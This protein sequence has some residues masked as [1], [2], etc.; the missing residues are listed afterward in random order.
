LTIRPA[1]PD[2]AAAAIEHTT[3]AI[4]EFP[5]NLVLNPGEFD[6]TLE[7][8]QNLFADV[9]ASDNSA[10]LLALIDDQIVG[11]LNYTGGKRPALRHAAVLGISVRKAWCDRGVGTALMQAAIAHAKAGGVVKRLELA[12][13]AHNERAIHVYAKLGF[14][15]EGRRKNAVL[16]NG[17]YFDDLIMALLLD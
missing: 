16:K 3:R 6:Y 17:R 13:Y 2:D 10:F 5:E 4:E 14:V 8:E 9:A 15:R 11:L 12:V 1:T 7:Y